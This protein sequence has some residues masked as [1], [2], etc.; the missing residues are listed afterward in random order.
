MNFIKHFYMY[1]NVGFDYAGYT[2]SELRLWFPNMDIG[3]HN[4]W[5]T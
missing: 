2:L 4:L 5:V 3:S 1:A